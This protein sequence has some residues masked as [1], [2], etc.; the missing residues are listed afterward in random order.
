MSSYGEKVTAVTLGQHMTMLQGWRDVLQVDYERMVTALCVDYTKLLQE[1]HAEQ[2]PITANILTDI[3]E[4]PQELIVLLM[5]NMQ[6]LAT[7]QGSLIFPALVA[8]VHISNVVVSATVRGSGHGSHVMTELVR[9]ASEKW[10]PHRPLQ[11][12]LTSQEKRGTQSFYEE[13]G[14]RATPTIRYTMTF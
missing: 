10:Q 5:K 14:F 1:L 6:I 8:T 7:A 12:Q 13:L 11:F 3:A 9:L 4:Q 2:K